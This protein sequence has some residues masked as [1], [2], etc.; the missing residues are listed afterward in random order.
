MLLAYQ[1]HGPKVKVTRSINANTY[2]P[3]YLPNGK[4]YKLQTWYMDGDDDPHQPQ[5][6][7][8]SK[9]K[10]ARSRD[11]S[12]PSWPNGVP[13]SLAGGGGVPCWPNLAATLLIYFLHCFAF[14]Y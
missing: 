9:V 8:R 1:F 13:V 3:P 11:Q 5:V 2:F 14:I 10:V 4:A 12:E 7:P 6:P